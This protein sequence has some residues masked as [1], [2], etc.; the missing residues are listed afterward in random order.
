MLNVSVNIHNNYNTARAFFQLIW[1]IV[2]LSVNLLAF[3]IYAII[4]NV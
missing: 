1:S 3:V 2:G 4:L